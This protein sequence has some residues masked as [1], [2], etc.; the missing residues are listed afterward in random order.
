MANNDIHP[1]QKIVDQ[2]F[3]AYG[4]HDMAGI[5]AVMDED[6]TWYFLGQ[7]PYAGIKRGIN[8]VVAFFD[9]MGTIMAGAKPT[10]EKLI[11]A[12]NDDHLIECQ[13]STTHWPEGDDNLDHYTCVLW[14]F[15]NG[16][17]A[18]GRHF[19]ADPQAADKYFSS[20]AQ[21]KSH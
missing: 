21:A 20:V 7:H 15:R 9:Q 10:M 13:H 3:A 14:T 16:K 12:C 19:F 8:E 18:E 6:V 17:I 5:K 2:Y 1:N 4:K 11:V